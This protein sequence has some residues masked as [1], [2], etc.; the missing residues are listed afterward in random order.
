MIV[1]IKKDKHENVCIN[2]DTVKVWRDSLASDCPEELELTEPADAQIVEENVTK[3]S[4]EEVIIT[5]DDGSIAKDTL[6]RKMFKSQTDKQKTEINVKKQ[7]ILKLEVKNVID[8][9]I[10]NSNDKNRG[11]EPMKVFKDLS[12]FKKNQNY[13]VNILFCRF[14]LLLGI[15]QIT[16]K[17]KQ[18]R[19]NLRNRHIEI[20]I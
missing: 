3:L 5:F 13:Y 6:S 4:K 19:Q 14:E 15:D 9:K 20:K 17:Y 1:C 11:N 8:E 7:K 16:D 12:I 10:Y 18:Y 2:D